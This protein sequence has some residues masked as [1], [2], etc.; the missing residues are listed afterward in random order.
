M[1][2]QVLSALLAL[3]MAGSSLT[4]FGCSE[5]EVNDE[6]NLSGS[7]Q[8][9]GSSN[10]SSD[11]ATNEEASE[12]ARLA[13]PDDLPEKRYDGKEF[14]VVTLGT[15]AGFSFDSEIIAEQLTGDSMNDSV[16]NRNGTIEERFDVKILCT[17]NDSPHDVLNTTASAGTDDY[18]VGAFHQWRA[19][20]PMTAQ[21]LMNWCDA[22]Y[23]DLDKPWH[24]KLSN[25]DSTINGQL[26]AICSDLSISSMTFTF[27]IFGNAD[28][29][30]TY[31]YDTSDIY[32]TVKEGKWTLDK[33]RTIT[34]GIYVDENGD[35][36]SDTEDTY[37]FGYSIVNPADVWYY[38]FGGRVFEVE[39]ETNHIELSI[40]N[41]RTVEMYDAL[42]SFH[43]QNQG[44]VKLT[45]QYDEETYFR[46][47]KLAMAP[48]R[49]FAAYTSLR[50]MD[51][52]YI[53]IPYPKYD[54]A[55]SQYLTNADDKFSMFGIPKS[56]AGDIEFI[57]IIYEALCAESY[58]T[59][60]PVYYDQA[61][62]GRYSSDATTAEMVDLIMEGRIFTLAC[63]FPNVVFQNLPH[64]YRHLLIDDIT[65]V[66]SHY[67][68]KEK[69]VTQLIKKILYPIYD[70][71]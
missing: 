56:V 42:Y 6:T 26:Y 44:F 53:I 3:L 17:T 48:L 43:N 23:V 40:M 8:P 15:T 18:H 47:G 37:G 13:I 70:I 68:T 29:L 65:N 33:L 64:M 46:N 66:A 16:Y 67:K 60:Y 10:D 52:D 41:D 7:V 9:T 57:S 59:V 4:M 35:G 49:F 5:S 19:S 58:K 45:N 38:A 28:M 62:K 32:S 39:P 50:E 11:A 27:A 69:M 21:S 24:N 71:D 22:P 61:L 20:V 55:Q 36:I 51:S 54:E 25:D 12:N 14:R 30:K 31:G 1:K 63:Q 34:E 2:K